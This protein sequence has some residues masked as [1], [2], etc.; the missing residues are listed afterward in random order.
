MKSSNWILSF[1]TT[2]AQKKYNKFHKSNFLFSLNGNPRKKKSTSIREI[3]HC[4]TSEAWSLAEWNSGRGDI[5]KN[6]YM[7]VARSL[8]CAVLNGEYKHEVS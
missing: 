4:S 8:G 6:I 5:L 7:T 3:N 2:F 1:V